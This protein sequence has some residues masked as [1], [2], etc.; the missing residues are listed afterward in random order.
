[1]S[2]GEADGE[3]PYLFQY[4]IGATR[5]GDG[6]IV[7]A[8]YGSMAPWGDLVIVTPSKRYEIRAFAPDAA[9][10]RAQ[11]RRDVLDTPVAEHF[12]AFASVMSD[13]VGHLW[14]EE[15]EAIGEEMDGALWTVFDPNGHVLGFVETP[16]GL[17]IFEIGEDYILARVVDELGV[18]SVQ[19]WPLERVG[20]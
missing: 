3:E 18:E 5:L 8:N 10:R 2:I 15:Y 16:G 12:P 13:R 19:L 11:V 1:M 4:V 7:V 6:R 20:G 14:V 17:E 9:E